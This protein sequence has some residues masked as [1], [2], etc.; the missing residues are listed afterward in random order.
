MKSKQRWPENYN[1]PTW[2]PDWRQVDEYPR[3]ESKAVY[4]WEFLRRNPNYQEAYAR[5]S[6][7]CEDEGVAKYY[8]KPLGLNA[9]SGLFWKESVTLKQS[10]GETEIELTND[11]IS[12]A[13]ILLHTELLREL[14]NWGMSYY[15]LDPANGY[16]DTAALSGVARLGYF[17]YSEDWIHVP[18]KTEDGDEALEEVPLDCGI[19]PQD[20]EVPWL[21]DA[22]LSI[23][24]QIEKA[25]LH[26]EEIQKNMEG[27]IISSPKYEVS[28]F[29]NYL[30][31]LDAD[32]LGATAKDIQ[33]VLYS[34]YSNFD[35]SKNSHTSPS[36]NILNDHRKAAYLLRG[37]DYQLLFS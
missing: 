5:L 34:T 31:L 37:R 23:A 14:R 35:Y 36:R 13:S 24:I 19:I 15:L 21:F 29:N 10:D 16:L 9:H 33:D 3:T 2:L 20:C 28:K 7:L 8:K 30:R 18:V 11:D 6:N 27:K 4:A 12:P 22:S 32:A 26:L 1:P 25:K 17:N